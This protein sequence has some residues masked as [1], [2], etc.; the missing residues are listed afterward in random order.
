MS[1]LKNKHDFFNNLI[2]T[3]S[4]LAR[5]MLW[6]RFTDKMLSMN[7]TVSM[8]FLIKFSL[9]LLHIKLCWIIIRPTYYIYFSLHLFIYYYSQRSSLFVDFVFDFICFDSTNGH[10]CI[11]MTLYT[12]RNMESL[13]SSL[14]MIISL[15]RHTCALKLSIDLLLI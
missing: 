10:I 5:L 11:N 8:M 12:M 7:F 14:D 6:Q 4:L 13:L 15:V 1:S 9:E 2:N 3:M